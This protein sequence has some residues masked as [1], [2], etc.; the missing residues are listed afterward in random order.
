MKTEQY[1]LFVE[2][3]SA[4]IEDK[5]LKLTDK[6]QVLRDEESHEIVEW[7]HDHETMMST[8]EFDSTMRNEEEYKETLAEKEAYLEDQSKLQELTVLDFLTEIAPNSKHLNVQPQKKK[9]KK[10][11]KR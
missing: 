2:E 1:K 10:K 7:Y 8:F 11:S 5:V 9:A 6:V 4:D 3:V